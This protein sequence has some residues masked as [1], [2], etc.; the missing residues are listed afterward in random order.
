MPLDEGAR[1]VVRNETLCCAFVAPKNRGLAG[2]GGGR[3]R[4]ARTGLDLQPTGA[5]VLVCYGRLV[6]A[7][8]RRLVVVPASRDTNVQMASC[9][10]TNVQTY[11]CTNVA[12]VPR[13]DDTA[14]AWHGFH[15]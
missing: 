6:R 10:C 9:R 2:G 14:F 4:E 5:A 1:G 3:A 8:Q 12:L 7:Q 15:L 11:K 13:S